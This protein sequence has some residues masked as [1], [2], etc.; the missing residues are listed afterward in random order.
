M[1]TKKSTEYLVDFF[2]SKVYLIGMKL[3]TTRMFKYSPGF[4]LIE[5]LLVIAILGILSSVVL[6]SLTNH[7]AKARDVQRIVAVHDIEMAI[8]SYTIDNGV[9]PG[10]DG[11]EYINGRPDWIPG[12]V[13]KYMNEVPS[14]PIDEGSQRYR[15]MRQ[16]KEY[17]VV[18]LMEQGSSGE[19]CN[20][21][22]SSCQF[23]EKG[24]GT[25]FTLDATYY[26]D[27]GS[28]VSE[29]GFSE[30]TDYV[31]DNAPLLD[32][33]APGEKVEICHRTLEGGFVIYEETLS[34][35]CTASGPEGH[36]NHS[37]D[38][39]GPCE[40]EEL[41]ETP[42]PDCP[43]TITP[44]L[45][46]YVSGDD[47]GLTWNSSCYPSS[48]VMLEVRKISDSESAPY[49]MIYSS[50]NNTGTYPYQGFPTGL[51]G[52]D[53]WTVRVT[54]YYI[55]TN[56]DESS[57]FS[58]TDAFEESVYTI[59]ASAGSGGTLS[60]SGA[61][62]VQD[63]ASQTF[64]ITPAEGYILESL[65]VDG[66]PHATTS[67]Y[68]FEGVDG[69]HAIEAVFAEEAPPEITNITIHGRFV[70]AFTN[71]P[72]S[73]VTLHGKIPPVNTWQTVGYSDSN[74]EFT[75]TTTVSDIEARGGLQPFSYKHSCFITNAS[76]PLATIKKHDDGHI[77]IKH[78]PFDLIKTGT[79]WIDPVTSEY[80]ELGDVPLW[81]SKT[82]KVNS[83][84]PASFKISYL[85]EGIS[86][87]NTLFK[88]LHTVSDIVALD[89]DVVVVVTDSNGTVF[90]SA[91]QHYPADAD[92]AD[93]ILNL[94]E[95]ILSWEQ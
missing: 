38:S 42:E 75:I 70:H 15:Y 2:V 37:E 88:T 25:L 27:Y 48:Q 49:I 7:R 30:A 53:K 13:P 67:S 72:L 81:P 32:C 56:W 71:E 28:S 95:G 1:H 17:N 22:G 57:A 12:L 84:I 33:T 85:E 65:V 29:W 21:G 90:T 26:E 93:A 3:F 36:S 5:V 46:S 69:D 41:P 16:G 87:G 73:G 50:A 51:I 61:V 82:I 74:G 91:I 39:L 62:T 44:T 58:V 79:K 34:I 64:T 86:W 4:T 77:L 6:S 68:T 59:T 24:S 52:S 60:P 54:D 92:C 19:A 94:E 14:D 20:D 63:G 89:Y 45:S 10:I 43:V 23:L 35:N 18:A 80:V 55:R 31:D 76:D 66:F 78:N 11:I 83:D 47:V 40:D 9:P 8:E